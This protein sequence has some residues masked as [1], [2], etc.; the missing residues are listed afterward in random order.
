MAREMTEQVRPFASSDARAVAE[1]FYRTFRS[2]MA[3]SDAAASY[4]QHHFLQENF[5]EGSPSLVYIG[6]DGDVR[7]FIGSLSLAFE[8]PIGRIKAAHACCHMVRDPRRDALG[9]ARLVRAFLGGAQDLSYSE[10]ASQLSAT[11]WRRLGGR[12]LSQHSFTWIRL[13]APCSGPLA[14]LGNRQ[15]WL[16]PLQLIAPAADFVLGKSGAISGLCQLPELPRK[17]SSQQVSADEFAS[18]AIELSRLY[19]VH[20]QWS[21]D[22][23]RNRISEATQA[24]PADDFVFQVVTDPRAKPIGGFIFVGRGRAARV[25]QILTA[26]SDAHDVIAILF[27]VAR[28]KEMAAV[29]GRGEPTTTNALA[30]NKC[31]WLRRGA[32][33]VHSKNPDI[34][35][36]L[37]SQPAMLTGLAGETWSTLVHGLG[38]T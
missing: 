11:L 5:D 8:T 32:T 36:E 25:V 24:Q 16:K 21:L 3:A 14:V 33:V 10:T 23:V 4:F 17:L 7:G 20:P 31:L 26:E 37:S 9:G 30:E 35:R 34:L 29:Y 15:P 18:V 19:A 1:L 13:L 28:A 22:Q 12:V 27:N 38:A 2:G 6:A